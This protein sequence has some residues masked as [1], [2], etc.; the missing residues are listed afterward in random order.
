VPELALDELVGRWRLLSW[1]ARDEDGEVT[2]PFGEKAEGTLVYTAD[3]WL[4]VALAVGDRPNLST[5]DLIGGSDDER[6][7]AFS[8]YIAYS[9]TYEV[10]GDVVVHRITMSLFPNWVGSE[11][12]RHVD[13]SADELVLTTPP[14]EV[15]GD[16]LVSELRW[17]R[18]E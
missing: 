9:G 7:E 18:E 2:Y 16:V 13:L 5:E 14:M 17:T 15:G 6:A 4:T 1:S 10:E 3:G 8:T 12:R 11:R